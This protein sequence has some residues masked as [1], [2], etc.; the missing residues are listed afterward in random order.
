MFDPE[1]GPGCDVDEPDYRKP[2]DRGDWLALRRKRGTVACR[3]NNRRQAFWGEQGCLNEITAPGIA[4]RRE[5]PRGSRGGAPRAVKLKHECGDSPKATMEYAAQNHSDC[6]PN[7]TNQEA[8]AFS[9][10]TSNG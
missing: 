1:K 3:S 8:N 5:L 2:A 9:C 7:G 4:P 6:H 10:A